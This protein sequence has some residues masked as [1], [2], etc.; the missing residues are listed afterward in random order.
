[1]KFRSET[2][3]VL[4]NLFVHNDMDLYSLFCL[5]FENSIKSPFRIVGRRAAQ[6]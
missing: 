2:R 6:I 1:L 4:T 5:A 3:E